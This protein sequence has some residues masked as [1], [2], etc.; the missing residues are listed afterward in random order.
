MRYTS[1]RID[2]GYFDQRPIDRVRKAVVEIGMR[3][4]L[5]EWWEGSRALRYEGVRNGQ[6]HFLLRSDNGA[7]SATLHRFQHSTI[8]EGFWTRD[9]KNGFW[10]VHLPQEATAEVIRMPK[11]GNPS[12]ARRRKPARRVRVAA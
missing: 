1:V 8:L 7:G 5:V 6:G 11:A 12:A 4:I 10:R 3:T 9:G 2:L